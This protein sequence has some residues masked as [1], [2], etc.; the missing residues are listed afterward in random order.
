[1]ELFHQ[2]VMRL[3]DRGGVSAGGKAEDGIGFVDP[4][5]GMAT[6]RPRPGLFTSQLVAPV[7]LAAVEIGLQQASPVLVLG[8]SFA[9]QRQQ[10]RQA[11]LLQPHAGA[12]AAQDRARHR[13]G[14]VVKRHA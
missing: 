2:P 13:A 3:L 8:A 1:M 5:I 10:L 6:L 14:V 4:D 7:R 9:Q 12:P 11:Q